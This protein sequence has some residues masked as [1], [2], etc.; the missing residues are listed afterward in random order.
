MRVDIRE[1]RTLNECSF[2]FVE[3]QLEYEMRLRECWDQTHLKLYQ[4]RLQVL[5]HQL[6]LNF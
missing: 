3:P 6:T 5:L 1:F 4:H 2:L